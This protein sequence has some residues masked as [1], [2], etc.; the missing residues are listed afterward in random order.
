VF[1]VIDFAG[2]AGGAVVGFRN[3]GDG[4][5]VEFKLPVELSVCRTV[6]NF[7]GHVGGAVLGLINKGD[8]AGVEIKR[9]VELSMCTT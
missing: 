6:V 9:P 5:D 8:G 3:S 1:P 7:A 4:A 2:H